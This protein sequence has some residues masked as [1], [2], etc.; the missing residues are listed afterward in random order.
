MN[1]YF[2]NKRYLV[3]GVIIFIISVYL[4]LNSAVADITPVIFYTYTACFAGFLVVAVLILCCFIYKDR[5]LTSGII[6]AL[7][8]VLIFISGSARTFYVNEE[9]ALNRQIILDGTTLRG[10]VSSPVEISSSGKSYA[11]NADIYRISS[12]ENFQDTD[13]PIKVLLYIPVGSASM[14]EFGESFECKLA[15]EISSTPSYKGAFDYNRYL[16]QKKICCVVYCSGYTKTDDVY[17]LPYTDRL[18]HLGIKLRSLIATSCESAIYSAN[19]EAL[20]KGIMLGDNSGFSDTLYEKYT[21]SGLVHI[22]SVSGMHTSYLFLVLSLILSFLKIPRRLYPFFVIPVLIIFGAVAL[23]TPSVSRAIIMLSVLLLAPLFLRK[24]DSITAL[25]ISAAI[26]IFNNPFSLESYSLILSYGAT[27]GILIFS[28]PLYRLILPFIT[29]K[30]KGLFKP[31]LPV[32]YATNSVCLTAGGIIG[33]A[34]FTARFFGRV[35]LAGLVANIFIFPLVAIS[36][37][38]GY[39]NCIFYYLSP[40]LFHLVATFVLKPVLYLTNTF[41]YLFANNALA[42][43]TPYPDKAF[44]IVYIVICYLFYLL[45]TSMIDRRERKQRDTH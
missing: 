28:A 38:G 9:L 33:T 5:K 45:L 39:I 41:S 25:A 34:Y 42:L 10:I 3:I 29:I 40:S 30:R 18:K 37:V 6:S 15:Y 27:L 31:Y 2:L 11:I 17:K 43:N 44:F 20:L 24:N 19:E 16:K 8:I 4:G 23:F 21:D 22:I 32:R 13:K 12:D 26:I 14:P 1:F 7:I 36:F 35:P